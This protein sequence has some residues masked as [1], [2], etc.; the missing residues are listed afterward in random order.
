MYFHEIKEAAALFDSHTHVHSLDP[1][2]LTEQV[3]S[4][5]LEAGVT[6]MLTLGVNVQDS[7]RAVALAERYPQIYATAGIHPT[8]ASGV[9]GD[10][11]R[12]IGDLLDHP[13]VVA[14]GEIGL[15]YYWDSATPE[16]QRT[17][18]RQMLRLALEKGKPVVIH[19]RDSTDDLVSITG[20][21][22]F[23][24]VRGV[25]HCYAGPSTYAGP[26][27]DRGYSVSFAGN[28]TFKNYQD[29]DVV[30]M[31]PGDR[32]L[33]ETDTPYLAPVPMRGKRNEPKYIRYTIEKLAQLRGV[34][35]EIIAAETAR[36]AARFFCIDDGNGDV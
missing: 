24:E 6:Q 5:A 16:D 17:L 23:S 26:M 30:P 21:A 36:N 29:R 35:T 20:E 31:I 22:E 1:P 27:L 12:A 11:I 10:D 33:A 32:L 25:L 15:D 7:L 9:T 8:E 14:V 19:N 18:L 3:I 13:R 34:P 28:V 2:D 4:D